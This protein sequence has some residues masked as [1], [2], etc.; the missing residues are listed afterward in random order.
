MSPARRIPPRRLRPPQLALL[1]LLAGIALLLLPE[2]ATRLVFAESLDP[3]DVVA[4]LLFLAAGTAGAWYLGTLVTADFDREAAARVAGEQRE[5]ALGEAIAA[6]EQRER[7]LGEVIDAVPAAVLLLGDGEG[8][9]ITHANPAAIRLLALDGGRVPLGRLADALPLDASTIDAIT[10]SLG[11][12]RRWAGERTVDTDLGRRIPLA[13]AATPVAAGTGVHAVLVA[14][15]RTE[16]QFAERE[17][18]RLAVELEG[19]VQTAPVG[20]VTVG[21]DGLVAAW[22]A[23]A[24]RILGWPAAE[25]IGSRLPPDLGGVVAQSLATGAGLPPGGS[26]PAQPAQA[27]P[28]VRLR[29]PTGEAIIV[30]LTATTAYGRGNDFFGFTAMFEDVTEQRRVAAER[31]AAEA[32]MRAAVDASPVPLVLLD[33]GGRV[34]LWSAA[35]EALFGWSAAE[36]IGRVFP[37][38]PD[39]GLPQFFA[40]LGQVLEGRMADGELV[41]YVD[42]AGRIVPTRVW[43]APVRAADGSLIGVMGAWREEPEPESPVG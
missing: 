38:V 15:D 32:R 40:S 2:L 3:V 12:R 23:A 42:R 39:A 34:Q 5:R 8:L 19:F 30:R 36:A 21:P 29:R 17:S 1:F 43:S 27:S 25:M 20:F 4:D 31:D 9:P 24:E 37:P 11:A 18:E 41:R 22:N 10:T 33:T 6:V 35:A 28:E 26:R 16:V 14:T 13:L 7:A